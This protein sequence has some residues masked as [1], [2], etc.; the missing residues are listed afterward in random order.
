MMTELNI[1]F[2]GP[3][4]SGKTTAITTLGD[5]PR[6]GANRT[7]TVKMPDRKPEMTVDMDYGTMSID[8]GE[9]MHLYG[10]P[11]HECFETVGKKLTTNGLG[12]VLLLDN[13]TT[14][15]LSDMTLFLESFKI[16]INETAVAV[17][18]TK[19]DVSQLLTVDAY[20]Q[21][22][23]QSGFKGAVFEV[24]ARDY[25]DM[26]CLVQALLFTIDPGLACTA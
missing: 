23:K 14:D 3:V 17:G 16:Y 4:G 9:K 11:D 8:G 2:S 12:L 22:F 20:Q 13:T 6:D 7:K 19:T 15:P 10:M 1:I 21:R 25:N 18:I 5:M 24:D 26:S